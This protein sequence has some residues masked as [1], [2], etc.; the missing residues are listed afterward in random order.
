VVKVALPRYRWVILIVTCVAQL[1]NG[2]AAQVVAPLAP[3][4]QPELGISKVEIGFFSSAAFAGA[5]A[6]LLIGGSLTD[7][8]GIRRIMS[9]GQMVTGLFILLMSSAGSFVQAVSVMFIAGLGRGATAP[10]VTKGIVDWLPP[11]ARATGLGLNQAMVPLA[12]ILAALVLPGLALSIGWR[13]AI[14]AIGFA[15]LAGGMTT[16]LL[17]RDSHAVA[18]SRS[19]AA[20]P[21]PSVREVLKNRRLWLVALMGPLFGTIMLATITYLALFFK[22]VV[23]VST[24]EDEPSRIVAA[25]GFLAAFQAGGMFARVAWGLVSDRLFCGQRMPV[26]AIIGVLSGVMAL[27][28]ANLQEGLPVWLLTVIVLVCG[29]A[30]VGW[31]GLYLTAAAEASGP[32]SAGTAVGFCMTLMQ[33][34]NIGGPPTFGLIL[35]LTGSYRLAWLFLLVPSLLV[36]GLAMVMARTEKRLV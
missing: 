10:G 4:F 26:M 34:G 5:W 2:L 27:V 7:R 29:A 33:V 22:E 25:G 32:A 15:I 16:V 31:G 23:L 18:S 19:S 36:A 13:S 20:G 21:R 30:A 6:T 3:I 1:S 12:G 14:A 35:D 28:L 8:F 11:R 17:Y 24:F 9:L